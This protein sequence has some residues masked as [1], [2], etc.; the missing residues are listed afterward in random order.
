MKE[1]KQL[2]QAIAALEAQ[3]PVL[4]DTMVEAALQSL[5]E[6][7]TALD[8]LHGEPFA[9]PGR[10]AAREA[11]SFTG[12]RRVVT[13]LFCDV[14]G[15]TA[16]AEQLDPE[17]WAGIIQPALGYLTEP[18]SRHRG[19]VAEVR[20]DG[21][22]AFFGAPVAHED[23][24][25]RAVLA[26][27][28]ILE[29]IRAYREQL[30]R[31]RG[32]DFQVRVGIHTGLVVVGGVGTEEQVEYT[33]IGDTVNLAARMEQ[34]A[35]P[36]TV[37]ISEQTYKLVEQVFECKP[38]GELKVKGKRQPVRTYRVVGLKAEPESLRGLERQ[39]LQ[40]PLVGREAEFAALKDSLDRLLAGQGGVVGIIGEAGIGKSRLVSEL[41]HGALAGRLTW[42]EGQTLSYGQTIPYW[43]FQE[44]LRGY[45]D[46][47][48]NDGDDAAWQKLKG[49]IAALFPENAVAT[50]IQ[51]PLPPS[52]TVAEILPYLASLLGL[53]VRDAY[54]ERVK[55][56]DG[57]A[58]GK[59]IFLAAR[60]FFERLANV[61]PVVLVF[62]DL[63]WMDESSV[64]LLEHLL[65]LVESV[66]LLILGLSRPYRKTPAAH[67][68]E[69][70]A[71]EH[72]DRYTE[73][74][75]APL[76]PGYSAQLVHNL[77][78]IED[79]PERV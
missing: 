48:N 35:R 70:I 29:G 3:R 22:L 25:Q 64:G 7:L 32:L 20:G 71:R 10:D 27:L 67:L 74:R 49:K 47:T 24:P 23:D 17:V 60:R 51:L 58:L 57:E 45:A 54:L 13:I 79:L 38:L 68:G 41:R 14:K 65:P 77:L 76:S 55:Y 59:Q 21:I 2:E 44:I 50:T 69:V 61:Q 19:T 62:E 78:E 12:E 73:I 72:A 5:R 39:G 36:G 53:K 63:H 31:G 8:E 11:A 4:G 1:R 28:E 43:P 9:D 26:G 16:M 37:Q 46:I 52:P 33:A 34:T 6:K 40:S 18:V 66:P 75:L 56:L 30:Q 15:S 42:L